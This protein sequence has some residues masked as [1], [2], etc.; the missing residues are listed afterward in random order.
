MV[1]SVIYMGNAINY[2]ISVDW[3]HLDVRCPA[4]LA[5]DRKYVGDEVTVSFDPDHASVVIG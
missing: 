4:T 1:D 5:G 3:M 2:S